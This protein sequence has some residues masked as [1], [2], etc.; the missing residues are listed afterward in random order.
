MVF[1]FTSSTNMINA[2]TALEEAG[3]EFTPDLLSNQI[4]VGSR[5]KDAQEIIREE[6]GRVVH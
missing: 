3:H 6:G 5:D 4:E 1:Q 2:L